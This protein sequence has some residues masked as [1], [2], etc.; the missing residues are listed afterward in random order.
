[1]FRDVLFI[2]ERCAGLTWG[3]TELMPTQCYHDQWL[4]QYYKKSHKT[5]YIETRAL[6]DVLK[7]SY[8]ICPKLRPSL[9]KA[10]SQVP[11]GFAVERFS[12]TTQGT[13]L[14]MYTQYTCMHTYYNIHTATMYVIKTEFPRVLTMLHCH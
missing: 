7:N 2:G 12:R 5:R 9:T 13:I 1:M 10:M 11:K 4:L 14:S 6:H 8:L 3:S